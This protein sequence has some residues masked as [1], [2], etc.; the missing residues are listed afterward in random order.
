[1]E[2]KSEILKHLG[3]PV[4]AEVTADVNAMVEHALSELPTVA[5]F[6]YLYAE[7]STLP[8]F[9]HNADGYREYLAGADVIVLCATTL[10][11]GIDRYMQRLQLTD[12]AYAVV[13]DAAAGVFLEEQ[14]DRYE[15]SLPYPALGFRFCPGYGGTPLTDARKI[16]D[17]VHAENIGITFLESGLMV[18]SKSM[19]GVLRVGGGARK[20]CTGCVNFDGCGYRARGERCWR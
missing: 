10:G 13:F 20:S 1:M 7:F 17:L 2:V 6:R 11:A 15:S 3:Y 9:L 5:D 4:G 18:P 14:A 19:T 16:A 12:M 8:D